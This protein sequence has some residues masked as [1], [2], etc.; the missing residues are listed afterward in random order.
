MGTKVAQDSRGLSQDRCQN[1]LVQENSRCPGWT[2]GMG[3]AHYSLIFLRG[4]SFELSGRVRYVEHFLDGR[5]DGTFLAQ[6]A[7]HLYLGTLFQRGFIADHPLL[8]VFHEIKEL[9]FSLANAMSAHERRYF[10]GLDKTA[11]WGTGR[12]SH[13]IYFTPQKEIA[14]E[15]LS[16]GGGS[17]EMLLP[18]RQA[19][20]LLRTV[21]LSEQQMSTYYLAQELFELLQR[22]LY[23]TMLVELE[24]GRWP[25]NEPN[26]E[27]CEYRLDSPIE[28]KDLRF[29]LLRDGS[30][31]RPPS[32]EERK[33]GRGLAVQL[34]ERLRKG[35]SDIKLPLSS[36]YKLRL[37]ATGMGW[38]AR[39]EFL[40]LRD[41]FITGP[42]V[43]VDESEDG[44]YL[45]SFA[46]KPLAELPVGVVRMR[47]MARM[48]LASLLYLD[49]VLNWHDEIS[50]RSGTV[51]FGLMPRWFWKRF[52]TTDMLP[53][54]SLKFGGGS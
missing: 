34:A 15:Y 29:E 11:Y 35:E 48:R 38:E 4:L 22:G 3:A 36:V 53:G 13:G 51:D 32:L 27:R 6:G 20:D 43:P 1:T 49:P 44:D 14:L 19:L 31:R 23:D 5:V 28:P 42:P 25:V 50:Q 26:P 52:F 10:S 41:W 16:R 24:P 21:R 7:S 40:E 8:P 30:L 33:F 17:G 46:W 18:V 39:S 47:H 9:L 45:L 37:V 12:G 54:F 2:I